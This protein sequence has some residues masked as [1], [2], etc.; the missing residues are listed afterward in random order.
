MPTSKIFT[1][2]Q[3]N[4]TL[5]QS[6]KI[7]DDIYLHSVNNSDP[8][9]AFSV[10]ASKK[11][12][13]VDEF[14]PCETQFLMQFIGTVVLDTLPLIEETLDDSLSTEQECIGVVRHHEIN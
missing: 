3:Q 9:D 4:R 1:V 11:K 10:I 7:L 13:E 14:V 2:L 8:A 6:N 5:L 12:C